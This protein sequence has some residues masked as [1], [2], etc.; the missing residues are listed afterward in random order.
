MAAQCAHPQHDSQSSEVPSHVTT[1]PL[2]VLQAL[3][4]DWWGCR[5]LDQT[6]L[7][8]EGQ[9]E[10]RKQKREEGRGGR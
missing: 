1:V 8:Q 7:R 6:G 9:V 10:K 5:R 2:E 3:R 4:F